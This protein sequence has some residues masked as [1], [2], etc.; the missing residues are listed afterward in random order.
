MTHFTTGGPKTPAPESLGLSA[1]LR[2]LCFGVSMPKPVNASSP[3]DF[4]MSFKVIL[5]N[6]ENPPLELWWVKNETSRGTV[7]LF[8]GYATP[9]DSLLPAA[10]VFT[11]LGYSCLLLDFRGA[12]GSGGMATSIGY[13]EANDVTRA[14]RYAL[15][16]HLPGPL[17]LYA[18]SM[19][20][21]AVLRSISLGEIAPSALIL[22]CPFDRLST[23]VK[24]RF[25]AMG[26]PT[27]P[28]AD[29]LLFWGGIQSGFNAFTHNPFQY[30]RAVRCPV[31][32]MHGEAD[33]RVTLYEV[34]R[35]YDSI[36]GQ[37]Q[38]QLFPGLGHELYVT[39]S[40]QEWRNAVEQFLSAFDVK[41]TK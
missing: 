10:K 33:P 26:V 4:G 31:L 19:G 22:E 39:A 34:R 11:E 30:A 27:F 14:V 20:A 40:P 35:V 36:P 24:H 28:L 29:V 2:V 15:A 37:K 41:D 38:L 32:L 21:A 5:L 3:G 18:G 1:K 25:E 16:Q 7:L 23:T 12:G 8:P 13:H 6:E 9:K 17:I